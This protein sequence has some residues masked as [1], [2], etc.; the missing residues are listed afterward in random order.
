MSEWLTV[1]RP[2]GVHVVPLDDVI[3]HD[4][5][6]SC[7][8]APKVSLVSA[9]DIIVCAGGQHRATQFVRRMIVHE[10]MD[11]RE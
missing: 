4:E 5:T 6:S 7:M 10:A 8:C 11:G 2:G 3:P 1:D 9:P